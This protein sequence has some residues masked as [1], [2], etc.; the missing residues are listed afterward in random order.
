MSVRIYLPSLQFSLMAI[1][2]VLATGLIATA[3]YT[4]RPPAS[5]IESV[6][7]PNMAQGGAGTP[8]QDSLKAVQAGSGVELPPAPDQDTVEALR[9]TAQ[10]NN[11]TD[12][13]SRTLLVNLTN[14]KAQGLGDDIPTQN[15]LIASA[16]GQ[17]DQSATTQTYTRSDLT[18]VA[19][20]P[21]TKHAYGNALALVFAQNQHNSY[22]ETMV[23]IDNATAQN[24]TEELKKLQSIAE[25]YKKTARALLN[26][27]VPQ[28][29]SPFHL[30][31]VNNFQKIIG[32]YGYME[33]ILTDPIRGLTAVKDY[34]SL[35]QE[36]L[37][38]FI[39]IAQTLG[40]DGILFTKDEPGSAWGI[41]LSA[42]Q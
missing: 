13:I 14:A 26:T 32:S 17:I 23:A 29:L 28:T 5:V 38:V 25:N 34:Q 12:S 6:T 40:K 30:Q 3:K 18:I 1:S 24:N 27:P 9:Q 36:T 10:T 42:Q 39:N 35:T 7:S 19:D 21:N 22:A 33:T 15:Q 41:L 20:S 16:V 37:R 8:W 31:L 4:T 11:L 2:V